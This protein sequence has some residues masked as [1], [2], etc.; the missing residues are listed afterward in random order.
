MCNVYKVDEK[1]LKIVINAQKV[2]QELLKIGAVPIWTKFA[3]FRHEKVSYSDDK[4]SLENQ[5]R[6]Q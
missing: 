5:S 1:I 3:K 6:S 2:E 4:L